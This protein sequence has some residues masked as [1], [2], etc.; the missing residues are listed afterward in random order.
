M[1]DKTQKSAMIQCHLNATQ[2]SEGKKKNQEQMANEY[3]VL[4]I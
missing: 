2:I 4:F 1:P 3:T